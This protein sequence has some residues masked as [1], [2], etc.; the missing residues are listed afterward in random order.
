MPRTRS[1]KK[2]ALEL[3]EKLP[4]QASWDDIMYELYVR[5]KIS[6]GVAAADAG[7]VVSH[8]EVRRRFVR[9]R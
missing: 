4:A 5:Q 2:E 1:A 6:T 9:A 8:D 7:Q 3:I